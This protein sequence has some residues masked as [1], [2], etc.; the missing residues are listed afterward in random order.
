MIN[1]LLL[2]AHWLPLCA[3]WTSASSCHFLFHFHSSLL[4]TIRGLPV[5]VATGG[6]SLMWHLHSSSW[7]ANFVIGLLQRVPHG[8]VGHVLGGNRSYLSYLLI[9]LLHAWILQLRSIVQYYWPSSVEIWIFVLKVA[10]A[11]MVSGIGSNLII[12]GRVDRAI[13]WH[14]THGLISSRNDHVIVLV[15][16]VHRHFIFL[17]VAQFVEKT[18]IIS[19][20]IWIALWNIVLPWIL[21]LHILIIIL[22]VLRWLYCLLMNLSHIGAVIAK[23]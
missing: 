14:Q 2:I 6:L 15:L 17:L 3:S 11:S 19:L 21:K 20:W 13:A 4:G 8:V 9:I 22:W 10:E 18:N 12:F 16:V 5:K 7:W 23:S 1:S